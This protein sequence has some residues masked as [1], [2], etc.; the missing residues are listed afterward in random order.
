MMYLNYLIDS[1]KF[2]NRKWHIQASL[3]S[4]R[5][6]LLAFWS[7]LTLPLISTGSLSTAL[8]LREKSSLSEEGDTLVDFN[9]P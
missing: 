8:N 6:I 7:S 3:P 9:T 2:L 5:V 4:V 1:L